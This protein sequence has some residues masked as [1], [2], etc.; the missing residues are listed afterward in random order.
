MSQ[1]NIEIHIKTLAFHLPDGRSLRAVE[2]TLGQL[3]A[4]LAQGGPKPANVIE[5]LSGLLATPPAGEET[6]AHQQAVAA[7]LAVLTWPQLLEVHNQLL[8]H[9]QR[10]DLAQLAQAAQQ[11]QQPDKQHSHRSKAQ[12][13]PSD[14][15]ANISHDL[16][17]SAPEQDTPEKRHRQHQAAQQSGD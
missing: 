16:P 4:A 7:F 3:Q 10:I 2:P 9:V 12:Q 17:V 5:L 8:A 13:G 15:D 1:F 6:A 11:T 14:A